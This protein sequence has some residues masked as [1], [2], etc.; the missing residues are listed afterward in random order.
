MGNFFQW[1]ISR[2]SMAEMNSKTGGF[3]KR[4]WLNSPLK[5]ATVLGGNPS[6]PPQKKPWICS[7]IHAS[8]NWWESGIRLFGE[9]IRL[10]IFLNETNQRKQIHQKHLDQVG[11][12]P[13]TS[14]TNPPL[15]NIWRYFGGIL[16]Q[17]CHCHD[18]RVRPLRPFRQAVS[19]KNTP[20]SKNHQTTTS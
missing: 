13:L 8:R 10:V 20:T 11:M 9:L 1:W 12:Y 2:D 7:R 5:S 6:F 16:F 17:Y 15:Y 4:L 3:T 19:P 14:E 18:I